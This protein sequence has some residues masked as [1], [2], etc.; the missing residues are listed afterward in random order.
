MA[1]WFL[2]MRYLQKPRKLSKP[3]CTHT[4]T[5]RESR[6]ATGG[7]SQCLIVLQQHTQH[8][9][10]PESVLFSVKTEHLAPPHPLQPQHLLK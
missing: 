2:S 10:K 9:A 3:R 7:A 1:L 6:L 4:A 5:P 8:T